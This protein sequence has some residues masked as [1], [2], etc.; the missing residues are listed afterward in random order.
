MGTRPELIEVAAGQRRGHWLPSMKHAVADNERREKQAR[1]R[2]ADIAVRV[3]SLISVR[4]PDLDG[5]G[6]VESHLRESTGSWESRR[7]Q[8]IC[9]MLLAIRDWLGNRTGT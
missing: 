3:R 4:T 6:D 1:M 7:A 2:R 8:E 5:D 9:L